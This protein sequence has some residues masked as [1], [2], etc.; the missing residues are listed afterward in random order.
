MVVRSISWRSCSASLIYS[1]CSVARVFQLDAAGAVGLFFWRRAVHSED[2][3]PASRRKPRSTKAAGWSQLS[4]SL[5]HN[6]S[7]HFQVGVC[8]VTD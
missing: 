1:A 5:F 2:I 8:K 6:F 3:V 7:S 4:S